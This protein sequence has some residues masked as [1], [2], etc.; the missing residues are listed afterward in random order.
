MGGGE[1][2]S[3]AIGISL[4]VGPVDVDVFLSSSPPEARRHV[5]KKIPKTVI[6][7]KVERHP[8][9]LHGNSVRTNKSLVS[10][11]TLPAT[12]MTFSSSVCTFREFF[13]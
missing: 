7:V 13:S 1:C 2:V 12:V 4:F 11:T 3:F 10:M 5:R 6:S 8:L 9:Q